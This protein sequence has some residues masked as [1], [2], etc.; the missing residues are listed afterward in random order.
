MQATNSTGRGVG[1]M[2]D[3]NFLYQCLLLAAM[4]HLS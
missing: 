4:D 2:A 1:D 3:R